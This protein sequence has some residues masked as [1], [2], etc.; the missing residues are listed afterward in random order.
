MSSIDNPV[1]P[2]PWAPPRLS[3]RWW[4]VFLRTLHIDQ[5]AISTMPAQAAML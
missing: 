3:M 1:T 2:S 4:P 5:Q